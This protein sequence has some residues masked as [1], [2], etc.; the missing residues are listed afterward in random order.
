MIPPVETIA[1]LPKMLLISD[2]DGTLAEFHANPL[3]VPI[4]RKSI[5][6]LQA[7]AALP[8]TS[9]ALLS[10]RKLSELATLSGLHEP[11]V[12]AGSHG[13]ETSGANTIGLPP[14]QQAALD[15][16]TAAFEQLIVDVP[17]AFVEYKPFHRVLHYRAAAPAAIAQLESAGMA[18]EIPGVSL[19]HGKMVIEAAVT[20]YTKGIW[21][22]RHRPNCPGAPVVF[23]GDDRSDEDG[24]AVLGDQDFGVKVGAGAT[25]ARYQL[26]D[27]TAVGE[28]LHQ[29]ALLRA[30]YLR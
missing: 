26:A 17:G 2:F 29:L 7:L 19:Q 21:I 20:D 10:G 25:Q 14:E 22:E 18:L 16:I 15:A 28:F 1:Q 5:L 4:N 24:F 27:V 9:V 23:L 12:L 8:E 13:A 6:A 3:A 11:I 30:E